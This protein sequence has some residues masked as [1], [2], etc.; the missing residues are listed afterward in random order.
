MA[1]VNY[2]QYDA[3]KHEFFKKHDNDFQVYTSPMDEYSRYMKT[4]LFADNAVWYEV[5]TTAK[6]FILETTGEVKGIQFPIRQTVKLCET[7]F[8]NSDNASS[9]YLYER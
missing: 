5:I 9:K 2:S 8:W 3:E 7:E 4:Y 6:E 1:Q